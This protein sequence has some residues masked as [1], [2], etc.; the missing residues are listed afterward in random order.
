MEPAE[1]GAALRRAGLTPRALTAAWGTS[2]VA[3]LPRATSSRHLPIQ[4]ATAALELFVARR[5]VAQ[6]TAE[7]GL[8]PGV[9][10]AAAAAG[11]IDR[12]GDSVFGRVAV[13]PVG[14]SL[15]CC[16]WRDWPD[17]SSYHLIGCLPP[18]R[19]ARWL[20]VGTG[21]AIAPLARPERAAAI[22]AA[23]L[24][25]EAVAHAALGVALSGIGHVEAR[26]GDLLAGAG[27][28]FDLV[29]F[30][31]PIP[32][33]AGL[34]TDD[35]RAFRHSPRGAAVLARFVREI[36][37][38]VAPGA[39]IVLHLWLGAEHAAIL[40]GVP[41]EVTT[42]SYAPEADFGVVRWRPDAP[43]GRGRGA[44]ALTATAPHLGWADLEAAAPA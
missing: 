44:R 9:L 6:A 10:A 28:D 20:D 18:G 32:A 26:V 29:T 37:E 39:T 43:A 11:L 33:E 30:N 27:G 19:V 8:G 36:P 15:A 25:P 35:E 5:A 22:V 12:F 1:L 34:T 17:D 7:R 38:H 41:G 16:T 13:V 21:C 23:D 31:L 14:P 2:I 40:D 3:H 4:P 24:D 42:V